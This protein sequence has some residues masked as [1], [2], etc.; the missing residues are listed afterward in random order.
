MS[1]TRSGSL[2]WSPLRKPGYSYRIH[3]GFFICAPQQDLISSGYETKIIKG[4]KQAV[5]EAYSRSLTAKHAFYSITGEELAKSYKPFIP[6]LRETVKHGGS[7]TIITSIDAPATILAVKEL[8][9][10]GAQ[11][12]HVKGSELRRCVIYDDAIAYFSIIEPTITHEAINSAQETEGDDLWVASTEPSVVQSAKK[13]FSMDWENA[14]HAEDRINELEKGEPV[15]VTCVIKENRKAVDVYKSLALMATQEALYLLP[16][17]RALVRTKQA[18]IIDSLIQAAKDR[19]AKIRILC[20]VDSENIE[21]VESIESSSPDVA[22]QEHEPST[23]TI[24]IADRKQ[25]FTSELRNDD[26]CD[27]YQALSFSVYSNSKP[28]I[29]SHI[30]LF[31]SLWKQKE[32]YN[33]LEK[34]STELVL[35]NDQL[36]IK[37]KMQIEFVNIAA[38]ELRT[39]I[40]PILAMSNI[41]ESRFDGNHVKLAK[42]ELDIIVRNSERLERLASDILQVA[43]I[44][45]GLLVVKKTH[46]NIN[47]ILLGAIG[48]AGNKID[49]T[50]LRLHYEPRDIF[51]NADLE[52]IN[53]VVY[54]LLENAIKFTEEG[55]ILVSSEIN[56]DDAVISV[57][58]T[59]R[60][61]ESE[62]IPRLFTK[63]A[64][65][66]EKGTGLGL[67]ISKSII[68]AHGGRIWAEN[69]SDGKGATF[70]FTL[71]LAVGSKLGP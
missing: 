28:T 50:R 45:S 59:G 34:T 67:Y 43:R 22:F 2:F 58:D 6:L 56:G 20:P 29:E 19:G 57:K 39:P 69:N 49:K 36:K 25:M 11:I 52:K 33:R 14:V 9:G 64:T 27:L 5:G 71:P 35:A 47:D 23:S 3:H 21:I 54:N 26:T 44:E 40:Q 32:L 65:K 1:R 66:S 24:L 46:V 30:A 63:F 37:D 70:T 8:T 61:I 60:G 53:Q 41:L 10:A 13:R 48:D 4:R 31:E 18:G 68:E 38:H 12:R 51:I 55:T 16:T 15:E 7:S 62:I 17:S 42:E